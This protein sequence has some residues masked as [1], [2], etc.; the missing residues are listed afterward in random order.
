MTK[1]LL[2]E[3]SLIGL[4]SIIL[5]PADGNMTRNEASWN[6]GLAEVPLLFRG[7][8]G[9]EIMKGTAEA[10]QNCHGSPES[11]QTVWIC[12]ERGPGPIEVQKGA[13]LEL[14][15]YIYNI[16]REAGNVTYA[17]Q[18]TDEEEALTRCIGIGNISLG[19][20]EEI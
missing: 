7:M 12:E 1:I 10:R 13:Q 6:I 18:V 2:N 16:G 20:L 4:R 14:S 9:N 11:L 17:I 19:L 3:V 15:F 8:V 5:T